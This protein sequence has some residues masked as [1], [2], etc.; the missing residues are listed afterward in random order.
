MVKLNKAPQLMS[1]FL[2]GA[3][4]LIGDGGEPHRIEESNTFSFR[5]RLSDVLDG[6]PKPQDPSSPAELDQLTPEEQEAF[7]DNLAA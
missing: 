3:L 6:P 5:Q 4:A 7:L 1:A 2:A